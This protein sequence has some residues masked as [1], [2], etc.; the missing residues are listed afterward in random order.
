MIACDSRL[1]IAEDVLGMFIFPAA[2]IHP[3]VDDAGIE[4]PLV[5]IIIF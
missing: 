3:D 2:A 5:A 1:I 4:A